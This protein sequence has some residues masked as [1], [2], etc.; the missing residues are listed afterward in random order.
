MNKVGKKLGSLLEYPEQEI[1]D[2]EILE[3]IEEVQEFSEKDIR[4]ILHKR[5]KS[6]KADHAN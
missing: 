5:K 6:R 3:S 4:R 1:I 2:A